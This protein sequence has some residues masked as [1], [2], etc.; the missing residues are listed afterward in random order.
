[1]GRGLDGGGAVVVFL[2]LV[3]FVFGLL[4]VLLGIPASNTVSAP[5]NAQ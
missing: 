1:M 3:V 2:L 4:A 5:Q